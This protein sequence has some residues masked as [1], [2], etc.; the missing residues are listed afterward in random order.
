MPAKRH[1]QRP[2]RPTLLFGVPLVSRRDADGQS[3]NAIMNSR[4]SNVDTVTAFDIARRAVLHDLLL[5]RGGR[6]R[7]RTSTS[8]VVQ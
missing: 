2:L 4:V 1:G 7:D 8:F 5:E 6:E 3:V